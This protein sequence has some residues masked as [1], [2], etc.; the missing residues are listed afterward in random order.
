M[1]NEANNTKNSG[2]VINKVTIANEDCANVFKYAN[3]FKVPQRK[4]S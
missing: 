3:H 1:S 4:I 2:E